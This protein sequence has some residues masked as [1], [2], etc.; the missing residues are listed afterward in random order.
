M[1]ESKDNKEQ[2]PQADDQ[3]KESQKSHGDQQ[4]RSK[5]DGHATQLG[6]G[7]DQ[8]SQRNRKGGGAQR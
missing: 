7:Q 3:A 4:H 8:T 5:K 6:S 2:A 1:T